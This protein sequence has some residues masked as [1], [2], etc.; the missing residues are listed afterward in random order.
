[1]PSRSAMMLGSPICSV[2][3]ASPPGR[4]ST[5]W[6]WLPIARTAAAGTP[7]QLQ[8]L[9]GRLREFA[10]HRGVELDRTRVRPMLLGVFRCAAQPRL[11]L[12]GPGPRRGGTHL[13][14][15]WPDLEQRRIDAVHAGAGHQ[16]E[17]ERHVNACSGSDGPPR[18]S[19]RCAATPS[20]NA[21]GCAGSPRAGSGRSGR[22]SGSLTFCGSTKRPL[23]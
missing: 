10:A 14:A 2:K 13:H 4:C 17:V 11:Q 9:L 22:A 15:Q 3:G 16:P 8:Q 20:S 19:R 18:P 12:G 23:T 21:R 1:M 5:V 6:P 7:A